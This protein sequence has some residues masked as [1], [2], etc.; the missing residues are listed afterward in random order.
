T[1]TAYSNTQF[2]VGSIFCDVEEIVAQ[3]GLSAAEYNDGLA[4]FKYVVDH[5]E[6]L[7]AG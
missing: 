5:R 4:D 1:I 7:F 2:F 6:A 3:Q